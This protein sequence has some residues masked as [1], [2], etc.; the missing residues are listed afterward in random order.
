M[1]RASAAC[2]AVALVVSACGDDPAFRPPPHTRS[3]EIAGQRY[4]ARYISVHS[5][6][7]SGTT[8]A[9]VITGPQGRRQTLHRGHSG[10]TALELARIW[11][12]ATALEGHVVLDA[13]DVARP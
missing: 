3:W 8:T 4:S 10:S 12:E 6:T 2:V 5:R 9:W 7:W 11:A 1:R 13:S